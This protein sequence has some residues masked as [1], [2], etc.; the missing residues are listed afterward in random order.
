MSSKTVNYELNLEDDATSKFKVWRESINGTINSN[1]VII[2][3][4]LGEKAEHSGCVSC[5][6]LA[7]AWAGVDAPFTQEIEVESL[8][9]AQNGNIDV[10]QTAT[11]EERQMAR[12]A[13]LCVTGQSEGKLIIS[14][15]GEMPDIDIPV[16][17]ILLD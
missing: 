13:Q 12:E 9:A 1:M 14:A 17:I 2:D 15:D 5:T 8:G 6:L 7:S 11:F 10:A 4:V 3:R 16:V